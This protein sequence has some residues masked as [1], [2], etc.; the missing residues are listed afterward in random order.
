[1]GV[2]RLSRRS[3]KMN[4]EKVR[5]KINCPRC[6]TEQVCRSPRRGV[7]DRFFSLVVNRSPY[8][9]LLCNARFFARRSPNDDNPPI[10]VK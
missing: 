4:A 5:A 6:G 1:M 10:E 8:R 9:C 7:I 3:Q 2:S